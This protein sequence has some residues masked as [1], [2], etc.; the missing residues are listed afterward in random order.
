MF[1]ILKGKREETSKIDFFFLIKT[2]YMLKSLL[3]SLQ[4]FKPFICVFQGTVFLLKY[5]P[6]QKDETKLFQSISRAQV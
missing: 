2:K 6:H 4:K 3:C 1:H 5:L